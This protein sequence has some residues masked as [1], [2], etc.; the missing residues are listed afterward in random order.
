MR[1]LLDGPR[2]DGGSC[3]YFLKVFIHGFPW[4]YIA[5]NLWLLVDFMAGCKVPWW[6]HFYG[7]RAQTHLTWL[8]QIYISTK[9]VSL[10]SYFHAGWCCL[11]PVPNAQCKL[12]AVSPPGALSLV[13]GL[14]WKSWRKGLGLGPLKEL[15]DPF[16]LHV[17]LDSSRPNRCICWGPWTLFICFP[18]PR[19]HCDIGGS[20]GHE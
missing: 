14:C 10:H 17:K 20:T 4:T 16:W 9:A 8:V 6:Q 19:M 2:F 5:S 12:R 11:F 7:M 1:S 3:W 13:F 18:L 15:A